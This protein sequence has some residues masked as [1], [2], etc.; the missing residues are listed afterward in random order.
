MDFKITLLI[1]SDKHSTYAAYLLICLVQMIPRNIIKL[2]MIFWLSPFKVKTHSTESIEI[3]SGIVCYF[4]YFI[5]ILGQMHSVWQADV[6]NKRFSLDST[7]A[8]VLK[9]HNTYQ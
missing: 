6:T 7:S 1:S 8:E 3:I 5:W 4:V 2:K 9:L